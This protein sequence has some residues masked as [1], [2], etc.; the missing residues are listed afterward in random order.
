M[1]P[2]PQSDSHRSRHESHSSEDPN[3]KE[4]KQ[5]PATSSDSCQHECRT[6]TPPHRTQREQTC[7]AHSTGFYE[8]AYK[9]GFCR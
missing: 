5:R 2:T 8:E 9:H 4:T 7:Q 6:D 1:P 3:G